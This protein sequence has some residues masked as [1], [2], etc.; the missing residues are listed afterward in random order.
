MKIIEA[1]KRFQRLDAQ[2]N[3]YR[4]RDIG[5]LLGESGECLRSTIRRLEAEGI[6]RRV[7]R[8]VYWHSPVAVS[9]YDPVEEIA[10]TLRRGEMNY[11]G[12][13]SAA[14]RWGVVSQMP[15]DRLTVATTGREGEFPT[16][17]GTIEFVHT[18]S[19]VDEILAHTVPLP[20]SPL[21]LATKQYA[22]EGLRRARR[23]LDLIDWEELDDED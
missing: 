14:S 18:G 7:A 17:F 10:A 12:F 16:P 8:D 20:R 19:S 15:T 21:R 6:L 5:C 11:I 4:S 23:S 2:K 13:E 22:V 1:E 9:R 3:A